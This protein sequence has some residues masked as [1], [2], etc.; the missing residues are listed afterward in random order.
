ML[1]GTLIVTDPEI[2]EEIELMLEAPFAIEEEDPFLAL[3]LDSGAE[4]TD[5]EFARL[6]LA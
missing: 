1:F 6:L 2:A 3:V 4:L 5:E